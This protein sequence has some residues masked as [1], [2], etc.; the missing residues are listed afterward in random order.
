M[1]MRKR[2][3]NIIEPS[4]GNQVS[5]VYDYIM[6]LVIIVSLVPLAFKE[7]TAILSAIDIISVTIFIIDYIFRLFTADYKLKKGAAS[8]FLYP[9]TPMA[10]IDLLCILPSFT[11]LAGG[12]RLLKV[13]R[14][15]RTFRV[16]RAFKA[17]RYSKSLSIIIGVIKDQR[18]PLAAVGTLAAGYL[19]ISALVIFNVEPESFS[20]F[21]EAIYWATV[22]LT[23]VGYGDI[24]PVSAAGRVITMLSSIFGI[25]I[26]A[27]P[28]GIITAGYIDKIHSNNKSHRRRKRPRKT[29][30]RLPANTVRR[31]RVY[32]GNCYSIT[33]R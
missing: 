18:T 15:I 22:S 19:L 3:Y 23:T 29:Q 14:L 13:L 5:A 33:K 1:K 30:G 7:Q 24:Y 28:A 6:I 31:I 16:F 20:N 21:F 27:L 12:F 8:F 2:I 25:A 26:V 11:V 4:D 9:I 32:K 10:I 17:F